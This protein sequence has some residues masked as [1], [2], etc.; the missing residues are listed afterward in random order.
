MRMDIGPAY[1]IR[2]LVSAKDRSLSEYEMIRWRSKRGLA[3][4]FVG[5][6]MGIAMEIK[7]A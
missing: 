5:G 3:S 1:A 2:K 7:V 6:G 4:A